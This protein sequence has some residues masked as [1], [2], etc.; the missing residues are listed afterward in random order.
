MKL[1]KNKIPVERLFVTYKII[2]VNILTLPE[3]LIKYMQF[4]SNPPKIY[5][6]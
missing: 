1:T 5:E 4:Q 6:N 2:I 3:L